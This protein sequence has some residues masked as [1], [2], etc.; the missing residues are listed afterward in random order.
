MGQNIPDTLHDV[1]RTWL[2]QPE[3][4]EAAMLHSSC[5]KAASAT[6]YYHEKAM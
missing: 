3:T 1:L 5:S 2:T 6:K 4:M